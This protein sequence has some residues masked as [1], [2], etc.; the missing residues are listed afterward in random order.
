MFLILYKRILLKCNIF[1]EGTSSAEY[2][3]P[4]L[5]ASELGAGEQYGLPKTSIIWKVLN[6]I[7]ANSTIR[8]SIKSHRKRDH[9]GRSILSQRKHS[10]RIRSQYFQ[11]S[12]QRFVLSFQK[13]LSFI[14][15]YR[16]F[17]TY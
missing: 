6:N 14:R 11:Y 2:L 1:T 12:T 7:K 10:R 13:F 9:R 16:C 8:T 15:K 17:V 4:M 3:D 5:L